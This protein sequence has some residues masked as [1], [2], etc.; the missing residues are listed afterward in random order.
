MLEMNGKEI[1]LDS[2]EV[3]M[4]AQWNSGTAGIQQQTTMYLIDLF[5]C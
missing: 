4:S 5:S 3:Q 1:I 2:N